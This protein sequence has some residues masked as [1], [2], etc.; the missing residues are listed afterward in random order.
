MVEFIFQMN[1]LESVVNLLLAAMVSGLWAYLARFVKEQ[2][3]ANKLNE[4]SIRS[5]Q[6]SEITRY[7]RMVV[8]EGKPVTVEEMEHLERC[9]NAYHEAG[10][11]GT[12]T[13]MYDRIKEHAIIVTKIDDIKVGGTE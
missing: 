3:K 8:E 4:V 6:R 5:M 13:L 11:N 1:M 9:Y 10:G 12:A 2:R 7:F